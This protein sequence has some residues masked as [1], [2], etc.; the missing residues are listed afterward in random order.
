PRC[1]RPTARRVCPRCHNGL[2]AEY[3]RRPGRIIALVGAKGSGKSTYITVLL[4]ELANQVG[5]E[6]R[7]TLMGCD[8]RTITRYGRDFARPLYEENRLLGATRSAET[9]PGGPLVYLLSRTLWSFDRT[10]RV[11]GREFGIR[12]HRTRS[13]ALVL[14][15]TAGED[16]RS[17]DR[18]ELYLSYI[19][20]ADGVVLLL[21]PLGLPGA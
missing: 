17:R 16:L 7:T 18:S 20:A 8:E 15:D 14:F 6:L 19:G 13:L 12:W 11:F 5:E 21:D 1:H 4:H 3:C 9:E 10:L 2:P